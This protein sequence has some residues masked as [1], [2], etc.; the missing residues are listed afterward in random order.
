MDQFTVHSNKSLFIAGFINFTMVKMSKFIEN[1]MTQSELKHIWCNVRA[2]FLLMQ[3][4]KIQ[5]LWSFKILPYHGLNK[6]SNCV[7]KTHHVHT[8]IIN[9]HDV[10]LW[11]A[12][13]CIFFSSF[14]GNLATLVFHVLE[15][16][17]F[18]FHTFLFLPNL[19]KQHFIFLYVYF[20]YCV[21]FNSR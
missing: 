21:S 9:V 15:V 13:S 10:L 14:H 5:H 20:S 6:K 17:A 3:P 12:T 19:T 7:N 2:P 4:Y 8:R 1:L 11:V 16:V 18:I